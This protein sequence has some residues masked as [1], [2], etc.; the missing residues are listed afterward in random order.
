MSPNVVFILTDD[1]GPWAAGCRRP[2]R[3][4]ARLRHRRDHRR[5]AALHRRLL[6]RPPR[7]LGQ[8]QRHLYDLTADP[9]ERNNLADERSRRPV[10]DEMRDRLTRWFDRHVDPRLDGTR[11]PVSGLGQR[12]RIGRHTAGERCFHDGELEIAASGF[13]GLPP[14]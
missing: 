5:R 3:H 9:S 13:P 1:Q 6:L 14:S 4:R 10:V 11:S 7:L 8:G 12:D 2:R